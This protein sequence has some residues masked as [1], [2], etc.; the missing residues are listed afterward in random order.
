MYVR[1]LTDERDVWTGR[2]HGRRHGDDRRWLH[3]DC[4]EQRVV[5]HSD[6]R[7]RRGNSHL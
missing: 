1:D 7:Q 3:V 5:D 4:Y 6:Q 2:R